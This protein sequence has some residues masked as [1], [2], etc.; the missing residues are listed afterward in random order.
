MFLPQ[1]FAAGR[2][3]SIHRDGRRDVADDRLSKVA[4]QP[5]EQDRLATHEEVLGGLSPNHGKWTKE[6]EGF[7]RS[8]KMGGVG[9][10]TMSSDLG[11]KTVG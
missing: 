9:V 8:P 6:H 10:G 3:C 2:G 1:A 5:A 11:S 4:Q 7:Q